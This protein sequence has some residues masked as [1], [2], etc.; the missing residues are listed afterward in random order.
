M[1]L[2]C[3]ICGHSGRYRPDRPVQA[4]V[5]PECSRCGSLLY[6]PDLEM[7]HRNGRFVLV[8]TDPTRGRLPAVVTAAALLE[9]RTL[10]PGLMILGGYL[11]AQLAPR[12]QAVVPDPFPIG[13]PY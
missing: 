13:G 6:F 3:P 1:R 11:T 5:T 10:L 7:I 4:D 8:N 12:G 9:P 2:R